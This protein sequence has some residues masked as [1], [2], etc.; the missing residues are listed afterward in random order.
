MIN[1]L[2]TTS[3]SKSIPDFINIK[4]KRKTEA[5]NAY[6]DSNLANQ[7][8]QLLQ[9]AITQLVLL[10]SEHTQIDQQTAQD[11]FNSI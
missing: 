6:F 8:A 2:I 11:L 5:I 10:Q 9:R 4:S 1:N 3:L 7:H